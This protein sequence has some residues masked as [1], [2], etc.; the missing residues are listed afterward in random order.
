MKIVLPLNKPAR[1]FPITQP[2]AR[3]WRGFQLRLLADRIA[4]VRCVLVS[5][6]VTIAEV[7]RCEGLAYPD[8]VDDHGANFPPPS[9]GRDLDPVT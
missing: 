6:L 5:C 8:G 1:Q 4:R 9:V 3:H 2:P 7:R